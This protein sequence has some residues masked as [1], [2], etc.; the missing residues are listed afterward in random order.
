MLYFL[1][2]DIFTLKKI[3]PHCIMEK[4][5]PHCTI[6]LYKLAN[7]SPSNSYAKKTLCTI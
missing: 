6:L 5:I 4:N 3:D 7:K 1:Y 2:K